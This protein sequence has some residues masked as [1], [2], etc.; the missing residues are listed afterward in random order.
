MACDCIKKIELTVPQVDE[1]Q[2]REFGFIYQEEGKFFFVEDF[3]CVP[4]KA[5]NVQF[6]H[7]RLQS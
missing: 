5:T 4:S 6:V 3:S 2:V 7:R 1:L